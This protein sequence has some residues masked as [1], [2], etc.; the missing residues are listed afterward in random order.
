VEA[1][2]GGGLH[3]S[4]RPAA[5]E[6]PGG[7]WC[8]Q[9]RG[10][11]RT[12]GIGRFD[13]SVSRAE[14]VWFRPAADQAEVGRPGRMDFGPFSKIEFSLTLFKK[15]IYIYNLLESRIPRKC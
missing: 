11:A 5:R 15:Y 14:L 7:I 1:G 4:Q 13:R 2:G 3:R 12:R 10:E 6:A 9:A 8:S